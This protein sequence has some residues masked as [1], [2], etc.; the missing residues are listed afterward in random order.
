MGRKIEQFDRESTSYA[1]RTGWS[2]KPFAPRGDEAQEDRGR[3]MKEEK[4]LARQQ[5]LNYRSYHRLWAQP[6]NSD[7]TNHA[8]IS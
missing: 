6:G 2:L 7:S 1:E 3:G 4:V 5:P 8:L